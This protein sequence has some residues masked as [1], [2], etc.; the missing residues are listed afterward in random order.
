[1]I[2]S[3]RLTLSQYLETGLKASLTVR[4]PSCGASSCWRTGSGPREAKTSP[5][6]SRTGSR[7]IVARAAPV[8]MF[9]APGPMEEVQA[10][11]WR[12]FLWRA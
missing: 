11:V 12:R 7:F 2:C 4:S 9:V 10:K 6:S 3:G 5:G 8:T 1:M